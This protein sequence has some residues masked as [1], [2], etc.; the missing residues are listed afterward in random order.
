[1][2]YVRMM[3]SSSVCTHYTYIVIRRD[4]SLSHSEQTQQFSRYK[5][6]RWKEILSTGWFGHVAGHAKTRSRLQLQQTLQ[7]SIN[8]ETILSL[9]F[10][11]G[12]TSVKTIVITRNSNGNYTT[13]ILYLT[14]NT[15]TININYTVTRTRY[16][17]ADNILNLEHN[18]S[19][20]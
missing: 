13:V 2:T 14:R 8:I 3:Y 6:S 10:S 1:M 20:Q 17:F 5:C 18:L 12:H 15:Y 19:F 11:V 16:Y 4:S 9:R 7:R